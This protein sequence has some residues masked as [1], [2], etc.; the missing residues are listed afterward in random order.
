M[1]YWWQSAVSQ[2][3]SWHQDLKSRHLGRAIQGRREVDSTKVRRGERKNLKKQIKSNKK[4]TLFHQK[5]YRKTGTTEQKN[6]SSSLC[7]S[8]LPDE[9]IPLCM[10]SNVLIYVSATE[11]ATSYLLLCRNQMRLYWKTTSPWSTNT[12]SKST[13]LNELAQCSHSLSP[14]PSLPACTA[15]CRHIFPAW[16]L[17]TMCNSHLPSQLRAAQ[18]PRPCWDNTSLS[19]TDSF[20]CQDFIPFSGIQGQMVPHR[21]LPG[22]SVKYSSSGGQCKVPGGSDIFIFFLQSC[23]NK[24]SPTLRKSQILQIK[25]IKQ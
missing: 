15:P 16:L 20:Q 23:Q 25:N 8:E 3:Y 1:R 21:S 6:L 13:A 7:K 18:P 11:I 14:A 24:L 17:S 19:D 2:S 22:T 5:G 12:H 10:H 4:I 9:V